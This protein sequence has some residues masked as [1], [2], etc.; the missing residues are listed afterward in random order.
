MERLDIASTSVPALGYG[1]WQLDGDDCLDGVLTALELGYRHIDTAQA[2]GNEHL[3]GEAVVASGIDRDEVFITTKVW[4]DALSPE[5]VRSSVH[6]SLSKLCTDHVDLLMVHWPVDMDGLPGT[7]EAM[8]DLQ[9]RGA[10]RQL[11]VC[12]FTP[13]Q[14]ERALEL[15]PIRAIQVEHHPFLA[16]PRL[17]EL[18]I[19]RGLLFTA[20]SPL[21]RGEVLADPVIAGIAE[22]HQATPA[23]VVLR[24]L[25]DEGPV[26][27]IPKA[28]RRDHIAENLAALDLALDAGERAA[29]AALD[30]NE[31][32]V[33]PPWAPD[34][35]G[36]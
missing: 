34:P 3:V 31:R 26:A 18:A 36:R 11:G 23:Q 24:W 12:N 10:V 17:L 16:Q 35:W 25:L 8:T 29:I 21:A 15:A 5:R 27:V 2:Y 6:E 1:T 22:A 28:T 9:A 19:D 13:E 30:R 14:T 4:N 33:I 32:Q 20:Y 7:L